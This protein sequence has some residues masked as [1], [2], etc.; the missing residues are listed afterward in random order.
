MNL[1]IEI[2]DIILTGRFKNKAVEVKDFGTDEKGQ[3]TINGRPI[4]KFRIKK[5]IPENKKMNKARLQQIIKE[6]VAG[7]LKE[8]KAE[9]IISKID[10]NKAIEIE[11]DNKLYRRV[12]GNWYGKSSDKRK[13]SPSKMADYA[14]KSKNVK[15]VEEGKLKEQAPKMRSSKEE[16]KQFN[17]LL[18]AKRLINGIE[19]NMKAHDSSKYSHMKGAFRKINKALE[20]FVVSLKLGR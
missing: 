5:L 13:F 8:A 1:D 7:V 6:E 14:K 2:G 18:Q 10:N 17:D 4:L 20:N 12:K 15:I 11:I 16:K 19:N 3:P 9:D